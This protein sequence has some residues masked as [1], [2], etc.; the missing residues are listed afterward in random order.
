MKEVYVLKPITFIKK[1]RHC[2]DNYH[3]IK[4][5]DHILEFMNLK[6]KLK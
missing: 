1:R 5:H 6:K 2:K 3:P 4:L